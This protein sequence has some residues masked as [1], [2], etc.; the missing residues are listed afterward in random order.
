MVTWKIL[1]DSHGHMPGNLLQIPKWKT[2]IVPLSSTKSLPYSHVHM[3]NLWQIPRW[4][5][6]TDSLVQRIPSRFPC[7]LHYKTSRDSQVNM[8]NRLLDHLENLSKLSCAFRT[9]LANSTVNNRNS[10]FVIWENPS[11]FPCATWTTSGRFPGHLET[12]SRFPWHAYGKALADSHV[13]LENLLQVPKCTTE[14]DS[15][16]TWNPFRSPRVYGIPFTLNAMV[17]KIR[18]S[19]TFQQKLNSRMGSFIHFSLLKTAHNLHTS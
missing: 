19:N 14:T 5:W 1:P 3:D 18:Y 10:P 9:P 17:S 7:V 6:E 11:R 4:S 12:L 13:Y 15:L 8:G 16:D 2:E